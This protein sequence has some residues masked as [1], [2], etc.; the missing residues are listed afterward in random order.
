MKKYL[1]FA[2]AFFS[3]LIVS[4]APVA[5]QKMTGR[6][7]VIAYSS[8][9]QVNVS[10]NSQTNNT[11]V[12]MFPDGD[13]RS[14]TENLATSS[15]FRAFKTNQIAIWNATGTSRGGL[16]S[17]SVSNNSWYAIYA[18]KVSTSGSRNFVIVGSSINPTSA[19][20]SVLNSTFGTNGWAY[21]GLIRYGNNDNF[22]A[23]VL[24]FVQRSD[25]FTK[26]TSTCVGNTAFG[27]Q[28][29]ISTTSASTTS[30]T[31]TPTRGMGALNLPENID[32]T[33]Y[34]AG[35]ANGATAIRL[36]NASGTQ[37]FVDLQAV[38]GAQ[39]QSAMTADADGL[40]MTW[41][42]SVAADISLSGF[43]DASITAFQPF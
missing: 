34:Q 22:A 11:T 32:G 26:F 21:L 35:R 36:L 42:T 7:P 20:F 4:A 33:F 9:T 10:T 28:G 39:L 40:Q 19:N 15:N 24:P 23:E 41:T 5:Y 37:R 31:Y 17:G 25:G 12:I 1:L 29:I 14:V 38:T 27:L 2:V 3:P 13:V 43:H 30:L 6:R 16:N 18:V 8:S